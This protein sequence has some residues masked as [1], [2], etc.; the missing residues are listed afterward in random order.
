VSDRQA[1]Q[2]KALLD[3]RYQRM[4]RLANVVPLLVQPRSQETLA[5][6]LRRALHINGIMLDLEWDIR[7]VH[8]IKS[9]GD[10]DLLPQTDSSPLPKKPVKWGRSIIGCWPMPST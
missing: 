8:W 4:S 7:S 2:L 9:D 3:D 1:K 5:E 10:V 6:H